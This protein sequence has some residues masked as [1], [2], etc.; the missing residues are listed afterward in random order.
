MGQRWPGGR[1]FTAARAMRGPRG[2]CA[3]AGNGA[4][5]L[6]GDTGTWRPASAGKEGAWERSSLR[7]ACQVPGPW[8]WCEDSMQ[9]WA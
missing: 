2:R 8:R 1:H 9:P 4:G 6:P 5:C 7:S 3:R